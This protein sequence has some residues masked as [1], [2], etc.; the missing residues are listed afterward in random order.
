MPC[1]NERD[2]IRE[3]VTRVL[4]Q[5]FALELLIVDDGSTDGTRDILREL[6]AVQPRIRLILQPSNG[7]KGAALRRGFAAT[8]G[9]VVIVQ[10]ADLE[11]DPQ[12]YATLVNPI[13][14]GKA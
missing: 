3:I 9:D 14:E 2:T 5:H 6:A 7:G 11:Y 13:A 10:D 12:D 1:Y 4:A 8:Q